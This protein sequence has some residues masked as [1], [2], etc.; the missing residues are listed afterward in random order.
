MRPV[1]ISASVMSEH[2]K[3]SATAR[4]A[5]RIGAVAL[6][7]MLALGGLELALRAAS[8]LLRPRPP[9]IDDGG[10]DNEIRILCIGEST[11]A[12][13]WPSLLEAKLNQ[14]HPDLRF[15]VIN[16][17]LVGIRTGEI[18]A[19]L[20]QWLEETEPHLAITMLGINDEG[21]VLVY[22]RSDP[23]SYL[24][25]YSKAVKLL[26]LLWRSFRGTG[27]P[28][29]EPQA[30]TAPDA[31][32]QW[33]PEIKA[34][35]ERVTGARGP[36]LESFR[37]SV[38]F[39]T[40]PVLLE[41]DS[42]T[43]FYHV[44]LMI[45]ALI[46]AEPPA[47]MADFF[48]RVLGLPAPGDMT[49]AERYDAIRAWGRE[50]DNAFDT[51]RILTS[52]QRLAGD[53]TGERQ[54]LLEAR[55]NPAIAGKAMVRHAAFLDHLQRPAES[56]AVLRLAREKLPADYAWSLALGQISFRFGAFEDASEL[57]TKALEVRPGL[58]VRHE[59]M[60]IGWLARAA[61][62]AGRHAEA[63]ELLDRLDRMSVGGFKEY[64]RFNYSRIVDLLRERGITVIAMQYPTLSIEALRK[65]LGGREDVIYVENRHNFEEALRHAPYREIFY[66]AFAGSFGHCTSAGDEL[67]AA[68]VARTINE[69]LGR[70]AV[71]PAEREAQSSH[72]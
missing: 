33:T 47:R 71:E 46:N 3:R 41:I 66:D 60:I 52:A 22:P 5:Y 42:A 35:I 11:T 50:H 21:N 18:Y 51:L 64:T 2:P 7:V 36:A 49:A 29:A 65:I 56:A 62:A 19:R 8:A 16:A 32:A 17:G 31:E 54:A 59:E 53:I 9:V 58:P 45:D 63:R 20:P 26:A 14:R 12:G 61:A 27:G 68:N 34:A 57:L 1:P 30:A 44:A 15:R 69:I 10:P 4:F 24:L 40:Q 37:F 55:R 28:A 6:G 48:S 25:G 38:L 67:I 43:P 72:R 13:L 23:R 39:D 70:S